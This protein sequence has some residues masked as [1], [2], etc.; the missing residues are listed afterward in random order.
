MSQL[1]SQVHL[2]DIVL[3]ILSGSKKGARYKLVSDDVT[4]GRSPFCDIPFNEDPWMS[5]KQA[6]IFLTPD[7]IK[8]HNLSQK[9]KISVNGKDFFKEEKLKDKDIL[10]LGQTKIQ[11]HI[12]NSSST[13]HNLPHHRPV[14]TSHS[15]S[16]EVKTNENSLF[17][18]PGG[19]SP[20]FEKK[21]RKKKS[22]LKI[23]VIGGG[24]L[25]LALFLLDSGETPELGE[26]VEVVSQEEIDLK[27]ETQKAL[28]SS[29]K[30]KHLESKK[31][32]PQYQEARIHYI[33]GFRDY[34][35]GLFRRAITSF[36]A[37]LSLFPNYKICQRYLRESIKKENEIVQYYMREGKKYKDQFRFSACQ[38]S[39]RNAMI[40]IQDRNDKLYKEAQAHY[41]ICK[42]RWRNRF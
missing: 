14:S 28:A 12:L 31:H 6:R 7:G 11:L 37:C 1:K 8:V 16:L 41:L 40:M 20:S 32:T 21:G 27:V 5:R 17:E 22:R 3:L 2:K 13:S 23:Y 39:F 29:I 35:K 38:A 30:Q 42:R 26:K 15:T 25:F 9:T 19:G 36:R 34:K 10:E 24:I 18:K 33:Q 4:L